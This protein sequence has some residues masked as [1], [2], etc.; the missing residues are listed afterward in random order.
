MINDVVIVMVDIEDT[1]SI[2]F[3]LIVLFCGAVKTYVPVGDIQVKT[4]LSASS[5]ADHGSS[6]VQPS[7]HSRPEHRR[8][9]PGS[10]DGSHP[11]STRLQADDLEHAECRVGES[12]Y[13][14]YSISP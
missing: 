8:R 11:A 4:D 9:R 14:I 6:R 1:C 5:P 10:Q 7:D 3:S 12:D 2:L 13:S